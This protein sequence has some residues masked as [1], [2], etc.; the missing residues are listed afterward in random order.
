MD[1]LRGGT[2]DDTWRCLYASQC[3]F[4]QR[5]NEYAFYYAHPITRDADGPV[6][7]PALHMDEFNFAGILP[8]R[9][10]VIKLTVTGATS[11]SALSRTTPLPGPDLP[12]HR[13]LSLFDEIGTQAGTAFIPLSIAETLKPGSFDFV[14]IA[15]VETGTIDV[16]DGFLDFKSCYDSSLYGF[17]WKDSWDRIDGLLVRTVKGVSYRLGVAV[18]HVN[19]FESANPKR[20]VV[21]LG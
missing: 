17:P 6:I 1:Q 7:L 15:T 3:D 12:F 9:T 8:I 20:T 13:A 14:K 4:W 16:V 11:R 19:A 5:G 10:E 21:L 2:G 18:C